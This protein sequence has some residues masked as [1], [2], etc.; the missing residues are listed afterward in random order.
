M[1]WDEKIKEGM[2]LLKEGCS[3]Q[4]EWR[5]CYD[6]PFSTFCELM[7]ENNYEIPSEEF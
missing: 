7:E 5:K 2:K 6:C 3:E 4:T 1:N